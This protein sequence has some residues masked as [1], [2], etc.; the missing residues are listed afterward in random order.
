MRK[1]GKRKGIPKIHS[2][3]FGGVWIA[4][5][6]IVGAVVPLILRFVTGR[7]VWGLVIAGGIILIAFVVTFAIEMVQDFGK[8]PYYEK[9]M[10]DTIP[11]DPVKQEAV[12]RCSVCTG[13]RVAGFRDRE[14]AHFTEVM[15]LRTPEEE[16]R[17][18]ELYGIDTLRVEY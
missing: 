15:V 12:V 4:A 13:E 18:K 2:N 1:A 3:R 8:I 16:K 5:G 11:Y 6:L 7:I 14:N 9:H 10:R 17:F